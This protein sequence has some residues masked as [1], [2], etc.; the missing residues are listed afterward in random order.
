MKAMYCDDASVTGGN[1]GM[2]TNDDASTCSTPRAQGHT[3]CA[4]SLSKHSSTKT[5]TA[6]GA[7]E[8][9][10]L[11]AIVF[12]KVRVWVEKYKDARII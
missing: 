7:I 5:H 9:S 2:L 10:E 8:A 6:D 4:W 12:V 11:Q 1:P 3:H